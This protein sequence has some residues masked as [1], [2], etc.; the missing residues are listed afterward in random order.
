VPLGI[1]ATMDAGKG[2]ISLDEI[3]VL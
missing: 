2:T 3:C 1:N